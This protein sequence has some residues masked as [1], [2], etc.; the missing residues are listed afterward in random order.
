MNRDT[1]NRR[2]SSGEPNPRENHMLPQHASLI[3][4]SG[5]S[6]EVAAAR[7]YRSITSK[8]E[9]AGLGF[10]RNQQRVPALLIPIWNTAG[11]LA[12]YQARP[13]EPRIVK[14]K[15]LKYETPRGSRMVLDVPPPARERLR[16]PTI[17]L[18]LTEG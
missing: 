4:A 2:D 7:G 14:G 13:D 12:L 1:E 6:T 10:A 8:A 5:I 9:L 17:P 16:D 18:F 11:E 3:A 15:A